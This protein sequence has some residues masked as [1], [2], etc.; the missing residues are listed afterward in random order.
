[1]DLV[2]SPEARSLIEKRGGC[3]SIRV[4]HHGCCGG[5]LSLLDAKAGRASTSLPSSDDRR[6]IN[7]DGIDVYLY[8]LDHRE[9]SELQVELS[10]V[11]RQHLRALWDSC[12]FIP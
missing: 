5:G 1:M 3:L 8:G 7:R 11:R 6:F 12:V 4:V 9:P 10:G 2:I